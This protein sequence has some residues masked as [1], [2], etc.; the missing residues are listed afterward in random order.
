MRKLMTDI[1]QAILAGRYDDFSRGFLSDYKPTD[2]SVRLS[3][4]R[5]WLK[6]R[7]AES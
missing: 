4:K 3:Q 5:Q 7:N 2:E 6:D 1:R